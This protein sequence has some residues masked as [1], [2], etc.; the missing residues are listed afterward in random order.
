MKRFVLIQVLIILKEV[1][2]CVIIVENLFL[3][4]KWSL[5]HNNSY[6]GEICLELMMI[7]TSTQWNV[8][9]NTYLY[10]RSA[11]SKEEWERGCWYREFVGDVLECGAFS[12]QFS[13]EEAKNRAQQLKGEDQFKDKPLSE[14]ERILLDARSIGF[15]G[16]KTIHRSDVIYLARSQFQDYKDKMRHGDKLDL[17]E[18]EN[19]WLTENP[20]YADI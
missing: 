11:P 1:G 3:K 20:R 12:K 7:H 4:V 14:I 8:D 2:I 10:V 9:N 19:S 18:K 13:E 6:K 16:F 15:N 17:G 5:N